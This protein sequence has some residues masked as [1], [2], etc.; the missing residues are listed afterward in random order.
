MTDSRAVE[1]RTHATPTRLSG[2]LGSTAIVFMVVAAAAPLTIIGG[3]APIGFLLG[4]GAGFPALY[5]VAAVV[6]VFFA[7]G[8]SA[9]SRYIP[10]PGAFFTYIGNGLSRGWGLGAAFL[11]IIT[12]LGVQLAVFAFIGAIV[13]STLV[14]LGGPDIVWW[15]WSLIAVAVVGVLGFRRI[16]LSSKVLA[17]L[18]V[19]EVGIILLLD[20]A[21]IVQGGA[22]GL[23]LEPFTPQAIFSG[24]L[25]VGLM[26]AVAGFVGFEATAIFRDE[27]REPARTIPRATYT[28]VVGIGLFYALSSWAIV[29]AW[30]VDDIVAVAGEDPE[31]L[32][33]A[34]TE[35][36]LG[37]VAGVAVQVLLIT[38]L[39]ACVISFHNVVARYFH[40]LGS[41]GALPVS[42]GRRHGAHG[43]PHIASVSQTVLIVLILAAMIL[44]GLDPVLEIFTWLSGSTTLGALVLMAL[45]CIAVIVYFRRTRVDR[46]AWQTVIAP[47]LGMIGLAVILAV[48]IANLP[49]LVGGSVA[50]A[51]V[52]G[53]VIVVCLVAG[54]V[55]AGVLRTRRPAAYA[56]L[57]ESIAP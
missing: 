46:R 32:L 12:Y 7:V 3:V 29:M 54:L 27:A 43:S 5:I 55:V 11:A 19:A 51:L 35:R 40:A 44:L 14:S 16:G 47:S 22:A 28:A 39:L 24:N 8:L 56:K 13:Q 9:M 2:T 37:P 45:T 41:A 33:F 25:G 30:G 53:A 23:S 52:I 48:V 49:T 1:D 6:L 18:L 15:V 50:V 21:I 42:L 36:Y 31:G 10:R 38:S 26:F 17:V 20:I 4:N 34:T 57:I